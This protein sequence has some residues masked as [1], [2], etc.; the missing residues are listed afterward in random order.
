VRDLL[1]VALPLLVIILFGIPLMD[2]SARKGY[3]PVAW[4]FAGGP[5]GL[6][7]LVTLPDTKEVEATIE[8]RRRLRRRG[9]LVGV[10]IS[11]VIMLELVLW[12][13]AGS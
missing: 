9:N 12:Q 8:E 11:V 5:I 1:L 3:S 6:I 13:S 2:L 7:L 4:A 10:I